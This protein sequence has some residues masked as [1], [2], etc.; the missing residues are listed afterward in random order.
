MAKTTLNIYKGLR[1]HNTWGHDEKIGRSVILA[2]GG[3]MFPFF[4]K[5]WKY[6]VKMY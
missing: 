3:G 6:N 5:S 2:K 4:I 1:D